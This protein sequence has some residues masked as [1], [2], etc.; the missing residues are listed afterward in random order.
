VPIRRIAAPGDAPAIF[1]GSA[2]VLPVGGAPIAR[3]G[4]PDPADAPL[5]V[6][7]IDAAVADVRGGQAARCG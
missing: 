1:A 2:A 4:H 5:V 3:P 7:A 6:G